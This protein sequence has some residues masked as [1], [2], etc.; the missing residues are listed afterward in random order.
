MSK[1]YR[2]IV[3]AVHNSDW[4]ILP[5]KMEQIEALLE[6]RA[7]GMN[8][9]DEQI[10]ERSGLFHQTPEPDSSIPGVAVIYAH[11]VVSQRMNFFTRFSGGT[12]T[13]LLT[14]Q[15]DR[16][17]SDDSV[18][19]IVL[20]IDSPGGA[21]TGTEEL[22]EKI[23]NARGQGKKLISFGSGPYVASAAYWIAAAC[24]EFHVTPS[25]TDIGSI[26]VIR[27]LRKQDSDGVTI[28][29][30]SGATAK[31]RLNPYEDLS[32][33]TVKATTERMDLIEGKFH[34]A[35]MKYR[36]MSAEEFKA[37]YG[38]GATFIANVALERGLVDKLQTREELLSSLG[39]VEASEE[40]E[41]EILPITQ[42]ESSSMKLTPKIKAAL[43]KSGFGVTAISSDD[44]FVAA[45]RL[46]A[47]SEG[48]KTEAPEEQILESLG[49]KPKVTPRQSGSPVVE[50]AGLELSTSDITSL[51]QIAETIPADRK[52]EL[53]S[54]IMDKIEAGEVSS[55]RDVREIIQKEKVGTSQALGGGNIDAAVTASEADKVM[56]QAT[57]GILSAEY[58]D[59]I[60][61]QMHSAASGNQLVASSSISRTS[62]ARFRS[63]EGM[64]RVMLASAGMSEQQVRQLAKEDVLQIICGKSPA[65]F[66]IGSYAAGPGSFNT[67]GMFRGILANSKRTVARAEYSSTEVQYTRWASRGKAINDFE[68]HTIKGLGSLTDPKVVPEDGEFEE[69]TFVGQ[70]AEKTKLHVWGGIFSNTWQMMLSDDLAFFVG[71]ERKLVRKLRQKQD[72]VCAV[73]LVDNPK[74]G[75]G[76]KMFHAD[77]KNIVTAGAGNLF[78]KETISKARKLLKLQTGIVDGD[79]SRDQDPLGLTPYG[80]LTPV[81]LTDNALEYFNSVAKAGQDNPN[82]TN[83]HRTLLNRGGIMEIDRMS[84][85]FSGGSDKRWIM[86]ADPRDV[87]WISYHFLFNQDAPRVDVQESFDR[88]GVRTRVWVPF[89]VS[90]KDFRGAVEIKEA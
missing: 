9:T 16:A 45:L 88:L 67:T 39:A 55:L 44:E 83:V 82:V 84:A 64:G 7:T 43:V 68:E 66:G 15:F 46:H 80:A 74:M 17:M 49:V 50:S 87:E 71:V 77:H 36:G 69:Q 42:K 37:N 65:D 81:E 26:G 21:V 54:E 89:G 35:V 86:T 38:N 60:P 2:N 28:F 70:E 51:L 48:L 56:D 13:E 57:L 3:R 58:G 23:F 85:D 22:A 78:T 1:K 6:L 34:A 79:A 75:D 72:V 20:D 59:A 8:L 63:I 47:E 32:E 14:K 18:K 30:S 24:D 33:E 25:C 5:E 10:R 41:I 53:H 76:K 61:E 40:I 27:M 19:T 29:R 90:A 12:S 31:S 52:F 11:G 73:V 62:D 4:A